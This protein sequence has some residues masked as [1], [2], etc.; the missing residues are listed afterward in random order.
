MRN[1]KLQVIFACYFFLKKSNSL[2]LQ[3]SLFGYYT[4]VIIIYQRNIMHRNT[5]IKKNK[6]KVVV[7]DI[8]I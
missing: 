7:T 6:V 3:I 2:K 8:L 4:F 5:D 1:T